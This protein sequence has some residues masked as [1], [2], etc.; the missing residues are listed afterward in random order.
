VDTPVLWL[1]DT[2]GYSW[3]LPQLIKQAGMKYF[4]THKMSWNQYNH[5]P[6]QI[7]WWQGLDGTRVLTHFLT[8]PSGWEFSA[9]FHNLQ[10][11]GLG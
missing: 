5:M 3:A 8:T 1:P 2:F 7:L 4:I 9:L 6:N 11:Y 10:R